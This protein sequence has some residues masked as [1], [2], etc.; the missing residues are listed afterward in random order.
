MTYR[1]RLIYIFAALSLIAQGY[2]VQAEIP[3]YESVTISRWVGPDQIFEP[4]TLTLFSSSPDNTSH[5][6]KASDVLVETVWG[7]HFTQVQLVVI[8]DPNGGAL[9]TFSDLEAGVFKTTANIPLNPPNDTTG[10]ISMGEN[11]LSMSIDGWG[12]EIPNDNQNGDGLHEA[13]EWIDIEFDE[14][15]NETGWIVNGTYAVRLLY[16]GTVDSNGVDRH[17]YKGFITLPQQHNPGETLRF[18]PNLNIFADGRIWAGGI[19]NLQPPNVFTLPAGNGDHVGDIPMDAV[20]GKPDSPNVAFRIVAQ[21]PTIGGPGDD[22]IDG[23]GGGGGGGGPDDPD[24]PDDP[25]DPGDPDDEDE[26]EGADAT[27]ECVED[28]LLDFAALPSIVAFNELAGFTGEEHAEV[29]FNIPIPGGNDKSVHLTS[30]PNA[31]ETVEIAGLGGAV[32]GLRVALRT[33]LVV[34]FGWITLKAIIGV[35]VRW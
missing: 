4:L 35:L 30:N 9:A 21:G 26:T 20:D 1:Q 22:G 24:N 5:I 34:L 19:L 27:L 16:D 17:D 6:Y 7:N 29:F 18:S 2:D 12:P 10:V 11:T 31:G 28:F 14:F 23:G 3:A 32:D 13:R 15:D 33:T 25:D 8:E